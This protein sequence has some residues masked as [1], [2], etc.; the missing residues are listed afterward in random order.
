M[1]IKQLFSEQIS[2]V[3]NLLLDKISASS[4][5]GTLSNF[6]S[7]FINEALVTVD[8]VLDC[9]FLE[10]HDRIILEKSYRYGYDIVHERLNYYSNYYYSYADIAKGDINSQQGAFLKINADTSTMLSTILGFNRRICGIGGSTDDYFV[11]RMPRVLWAIQFILKN[12]LSEI[13]L[14]A[15]Y[16]LINLEQ[17]LSE[18]LFCSDQQYKSKSKEL[19]NEV[20]S[21]INQIV[22]TDDGNDILVTNLQLSSF[23]TT[24]KIRTYNA[25]AKDL[26]LVI[27][28][29]TEIPELKTEHKLRI[30]TSLF[31]LNREQFVNLFESNLSNLEQDIYRSKPGLNNIL[32]LQCLSYYCYLKPQFNEIELNL[33]PLT[34]GKIDITNNLKN[35]FNQYEES[36]KETVNEAE[37]NLLLGYNDETLRTKLANTIIG[38]DKGILE[39]ERQKPHGVFEIADMELR[40][41]LN[42]ENYFLCMPFKS[43]I[44]IKSPTV[45]EAISYQIFRPFIHF[46]RTIVIFVTAKRCSQNLMNYIKRMQDKL[47]WAIAVIENEELAKLLKVNGQ[48][49]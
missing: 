19:L 28:D 5:K 6:E 21:L 25:L 47:G 43:G 30:L 24:Q 23:L 15:L 34:N 33:N 8:K 42:Q 1:E 39:R 36:H 37:M 40:V 4:Q 2:I 16:V 32:F 13:Y 17:V 48:L 29:I 7:R 14:P 12:K 27:T 26:N 38:V 11:E 44:E 35:I 3:Q 49:N 9:G 20:E 18:Y 10:S 41:R 45:P 22:S 46:D 31:Q